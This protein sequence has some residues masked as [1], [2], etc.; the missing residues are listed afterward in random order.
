MFP[1]RPLLPRSRRP[2]SSPHGGGPPAA[3]AAATSPFKSFHFHHHIMV[4]SAFSN[5]R[6]GPEVGT[7]VHVP[8]FFPALHGAHAY[9]LQQ[10]LRLATE[11]LGKLDAGRKD[12]NQVPFDETQHLL[13]RPASDT[14]GGNERRQQLRLGHPWVCDYEVKNIRLFKKNHTGRLMSLFDNNGTFIGEG[15]FSRQAS[16]VLRILNRSPTTSASSSNSSSSNSSSSNSSSIGERSVEELLRSRFLDALRR[17]GFNPETRQNTNSS[18]NSNTN[19]SSSNSSSSSRRIY[20]VGSADVWRAIDGEADG[21]PGVDIDVFG[22]AVVMRLHSRALVPHSAFLVSLVKSTLKPSTLC[23]QTLQSNKEKHAQDGAEYRSELLVGTSSEVWV[24]VFGS[25]LPVPLHLPPLYSFSSSIISSPFLLPLLRRCCAG[26]SLLTVDACMRGVGVPCVRGASAKRKEKEGGKEE[27]WGVCYC[28]SV[29]RWEEE[30]A[31]NLVMVESA[32]TINALNEK[33]A[34]ANGVAD[35]V[36]CIY[37]G[38][39]QKE[40]VSMKSSGLRFRAVYVHLPPTVRFASAERGGQFGRWFRP[41][42]KGVLSQWSAAAALVEEGGLL[43]TSLLLPL[44]KEQWAF[45]AFSKAAENTGKR[46]ALVYRSAAGFNAKQ[47]A[48]HTDLW[49][50]QIFCLQL[51]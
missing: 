36:T 8:S 3:A 4:H 18:N 1:G 13:L 46:A 24:E 51:R 34:A 5:L 43:M 27:D 12:Q 48:V 45:D 42:L 15:L 25:R 7:V 2:L 40:L 29:G 26:G 10:H 21:L 50:E 33:T 30:G 31:D 35:K 20:E 49:K 9:G 32:E 37:T 47:L 28:G 22:S 38:D 11:S 17:R 39:T 14:P 19:S 41:S 6:R 23:L 44:N 16:I